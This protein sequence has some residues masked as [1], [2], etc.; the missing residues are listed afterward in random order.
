M[1]GELAHRREVAGR[2]RMGGWERV[3]GTDIP[4]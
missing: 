3:K 1:E 4:I 2:G